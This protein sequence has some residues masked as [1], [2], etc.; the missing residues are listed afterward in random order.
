MQKLKKGFTLIE[1]MLVVGILALLASIIIPRFNDF[2]DTTQD[3]ARARQALIV[4]TKIEEYYNEFG[5]YPRHMGR[6]GWSGDGD[7][8]T[9]T[10]DIAKRYWP[11]DTNGTP[12]A[13]PDGEDWILTRH[14]NVDEG[15]WQLTYVE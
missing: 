14:R 15:F 2:T 10:L 13:S 5:Y 7:G 4:N 1:M 6:W 12:P 3:A 8:V 9:R 11:D